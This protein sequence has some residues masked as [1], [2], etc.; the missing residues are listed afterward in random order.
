M[1]I[2]TFEC[3]I[4]GFE[5]GYIISYVMHL[6]DDGS[7]LNNKFQ[8]KIQKG[9]ITDPFI[10]E[11]CKSVL[12]KLHEQSTYSIENMTV[13][14]K[15]QFCFIKVRKNRN[16]IFVNEA[17]WGPGIIYLQQIIRYVDRGLVFD[18]N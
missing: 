16:L 10:I 5:Y 2:E 6:Y 1:E 18:E 17:K 7:N 15:I 14:F 12:L 8:I 11:Y 9:G 4:Q 13:A 3:A